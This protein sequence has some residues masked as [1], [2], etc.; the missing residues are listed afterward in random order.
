LDCYIVTHPDEVNCNVHETLAFN[1]ALRH[2]DNLQVSLK[3]M[4]KLSV[5]STNAIIFPIYYSFY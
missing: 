3:R 4:L 1:D 5:L 2:G